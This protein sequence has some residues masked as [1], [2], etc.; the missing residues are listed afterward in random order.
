M[1]KILHITIQ[2][3]DEATDLSA[4]QLCMSYVHA[5][6]SCILESIFLLLARARIS[7]K[8]NATGCT[9]C[10]TEVY[11]LA[12]NYTRTKNPK[13]LMKYINMALT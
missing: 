1:L 6:E 8:S 3:S 2:I 11:I 9:I 10:H 7:I 12:C 13:K 5:V 4:I